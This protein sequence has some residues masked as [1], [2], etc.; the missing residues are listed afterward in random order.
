MKLVRTVFEK[1]GYSLSGIK[2]TFRDEPSM[3]QW[4]IIVV[5]SDLAA[6]FSFGFDFKSGVIFAVGFLLLGSELINT[7]VEIV[8]DHVHPEIGD[9]AKRAKDAASALTFM[10]FCA[11]SSLWVFHILDLIK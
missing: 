2:T 7:A 9:V 5:I 8:V 6:L 4:A 1:L 10:T 3:G 11:L